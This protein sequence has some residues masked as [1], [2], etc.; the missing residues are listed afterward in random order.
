MS[1][2]DLETTPPRVINR[3][4]VGDAPEGLAI[5]PT[6]NLA[7]VVLLRGSN[8]AWNSWYYNRN[9]S[10]VILKIDGKKV[11]RLDEV[12]VRGLPRAWCGAPTA[13]TST[14]VTAWTATCL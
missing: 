4:V 8:Q 11:T 7:A 1:V 14:W 5:S 3:V 6:G 9:G 2:I 12:E 10:V 13:S